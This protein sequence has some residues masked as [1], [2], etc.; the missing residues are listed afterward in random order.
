MDHR[1]SDDTARR[2]DLLG[3]AGD[4]GVWVQQFM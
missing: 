2:R 3:F 1:E 4:R